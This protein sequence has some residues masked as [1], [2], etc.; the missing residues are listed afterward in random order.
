[1]AVA[2]ELV[3]SPNMSSKTQNGVACNIGNGFKNKRQQRLVL[4]ALANFRQCKLHLDPI[5]G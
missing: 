1:M 4:Q 2:M 5:P 3:L